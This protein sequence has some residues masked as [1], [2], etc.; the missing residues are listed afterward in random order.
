MYNIL[1]GI[2]ERKRCAKYEIPVTN[3]FILNTEDDYPP[4]KKGAIVN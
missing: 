1:I 2:P 4:S 3:P